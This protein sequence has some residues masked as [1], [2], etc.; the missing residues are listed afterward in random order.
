MP[1]CP[2]CDHE[3]SSLYTFNMHLFG[4]HDIVFSDKPFTWR[5]RLQL[6]AEWEREG[7]LDDMIRRHWLA[8]EM[9]STAP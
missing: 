5:E 4:A 3:A 9:S 1:K 6:L 2:L 8:K 7:I